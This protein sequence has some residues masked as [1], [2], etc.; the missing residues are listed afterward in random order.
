MSNRDSKQGYEFH[1]PVMV[2]E[3]IS[4]LLPSHQLPKIDGK[5]PMFIDATVGGGGHAQAILENLS[6]GIV[7]GLDCDV[8][9][10]E[11]TK[12][13]LQNYTNFHLFHTTYTNIDK[14]ALEFPNYYIKGILFDLGVSYYQIMTPSRGFTYSSAGPLDMRFNQSLPARSAKEII[15]HASL[16]DLRKIFS[17]YGEER[18]AHKIAT[19]IHTQRNYI[20]T[21]LE[22]ADIIKKAI[23]GQKQNKSLSRVFQSLRI[24]VNNELENIKIGIEKAIKLLTT[25][26]RILVIA[27]HSLEDRLV[28]QTFR[29]YANL[30][31]LKILIKKPLVPQLSEVSVNPPARSA[32]LR[33]AEK[34]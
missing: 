30:E 29:N 8:D 3:V 23:P 10:I 20:N 32:H 31:F 4:Y 25:G 11:Y 16:Y 9:A 26:G 7:V 17:E 15:R 33:A 18:Y 6:S 28:K 19:Q 13:R 22:L 21:T 27:Y 2:K 5:L 24:V 12:K 1:T 14:V 34:I